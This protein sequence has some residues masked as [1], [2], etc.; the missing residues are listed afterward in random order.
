MIVLG[1]EEDIFPLP[2]TQFSVNLSF[3]TVYYLSFVV[4]ERACYFKP[5]VKKYN[6][7]MSL[8]RVF[9]FSFS[10]TALRDLFYL[11][12]VIV[13]DIEY[14]FP[15]SCTRFSVKLSL[16]TISYLSF[17]VWERACYFKPRVKYCKHSSSR[18]LPH[19]QPYDI[20]S[21]YYQSFP[22]VVM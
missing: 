13:F 6:L 16:L 12:S 9:F 19:T 10:H 17:V 2:C 14:I 8:R 3:L 20:Y 22:E 21:I 5:R 15:L 18:P 7:L 4:G 1:I 11:L